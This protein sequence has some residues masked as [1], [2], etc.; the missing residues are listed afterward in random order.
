MSSNAWLLPEGV[1]E[2][3]PPQAWVLESLRR[4]VLDVYKAAGYELVFPPLIE[5]RDVLLM[6][7]GDDV[8]SQTFTLT[9]P[10]SGRLLGVRADM[11][12]QVARIDAHRLKRQ[13]PTRLCYCG[14][15][16]RA[17]PQELGASRTCIQTGIE[18]YGQTDLASDLEV[19]ALM[20]ATLKAAGRESVC[21]GFGHVGILEGLFKQYEI[22]PAQQKILLDIY[23][24][25][26]IPELNAFIETEI[27]DTT[28]K[29]YLSGLAHWQGDASILEIAQTQLASASS[30]VLAAID[31]LRQIAQW[32]KKTHADVALYF[33]LSEFRGYRYH[34]G[35]V[36]SAY[37][38]GIGR[39][40]AQGG[41]YDMS[42]ALGRARPATG[43]S[44][45]L[46]QL[47]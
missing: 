16:L 21:L 41:R 40:I 10:L 24:R 11:T 37:Q 33:D 34:T 22:I 4:E 27:T 13:E 14:S 6:G 39:A 19:I 15:V 7:A 35:I 29:K 12:P 46:I 26:A 2:I 28:L 3:L 32:M 36:F 20:L 43:F 47:I 8:A 23:E 30:E 9:D 25:K 31:Y 42:E 44:T 17:Q 5:Y 45:D 1:E 38:S 18:L